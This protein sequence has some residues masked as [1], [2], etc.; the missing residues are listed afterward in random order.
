MHWII[1]IHC[2][3]NN[4]A[5]NNRACHFSPR[6]SLRIREHDDRRICRFTKGE[7]KKRSGKGTRPDCKR[8]KR[9]LVRNASHIEYPRVI[10]LHALASFLL[11]ICLFTAVHEETKRAKQRCE[12]NTRFC[13]VYG[14]KERSRRWTVGRSGGFFGKSRDVKSRE[15]L[16]PLFEKSGEKWFERT[17]WQST[18]LARISDISANSLVWTKQTRTHASGIYIWHRAPSIRGWGE[19]RARKAVAFI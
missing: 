15:S 2:D 16:A 13:T 8:N 5:V 7:K 3:D 11:P 6:P 14:E 17:W 1:L 18:V 9:G 19:G 4:V 12:V 10:S